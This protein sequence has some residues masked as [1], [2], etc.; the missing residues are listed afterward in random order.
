MKHDNG[1]FWCALCIHIISY[2]LHTKNVLQHLHEGPVI[3]LTFQKAI[4][5]SW[6]FFSFSFREIVILFKAFHFHEQSLW[7]NQYG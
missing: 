2:K 3:K 5:K 6:C 4:K 1:Y 7:F